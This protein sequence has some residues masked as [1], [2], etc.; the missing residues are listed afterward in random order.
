MRNAE[1][2]LAVIRKQ[3]QRG[4]SVKNVYRLLYQRDLYLHAY[5]KLYRNHG[6]MTEG[7]TSETVD[8]MSL[9]K[10]DKIIT[11]LRNE[12]YRWTPVRRVYIPKKNKKL[13]P[14]GLP[15]WS[16]KLLQ[17][18]VR[19]ILE[20]YYEPKFSKNSHGFRPKR[21]C[22]TALRGVIRKGSGTKWFIEG[23]ISACYDKIDHSIL[24]EI[25]GE[26]FQDNRFI[27]LLKGL[28]TAGY[29]EDWK[30]NKT[31]SGVPQ[32]S[33]IGPILSNIVLDRLDK[34]VEE[35]L[36]PDYTRGKMREMN[37]DYHRLNW[38]ALRL[39]KKNG[40]K[41]AH[42][43]RKQMQNMPSKNPNDS[44]FRR[45]WYVRYADDFLLGL[46]GPKNEGV[47]IKNKVANFLC[48]DL[49]LALNSEKT[50]VTHARDKKAKFLGYEIHALHNNRK[51]DHQK[52]RC[53]NGIIGLRI[54]LYV[55]R[56]MC[57][58]YKKHGKPVHM[59]QRINEEAYSIVTQYQAEYRGIVQYYRMAYNLSSL[60]EFKHVMEQSL[61]QTLARKYK[62]TCTKI[63][64]RYGTHIE[65]EEGKRRVILVRYERE[66]PKKPLIAYFGGISQKW[67][68]QASI[69]DKPPPMVLRNRNELVQRLLAQECELCGS[70]DNV[71]VHHIRKLADLKEEGRTV[72]AEWKRHMSKRQRKTL[73]VCR[74]CH[75]DI[76]H[77]RY[78]GEKLSA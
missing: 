39:E 57:N 12:Q 9:E 76:H 36:I 75:N 28:L 53:I 46:I 20:A 17:E 60:G 61:V 10:I 30:F 71:E 72:Q 74:A 63:Y 16:D 49:K 32:G 67:D 18:V 5:G 41:R 7:A 24:L 21:G 15:K 58:K 52:R 6:A 55:K 50:L 38:Q 37:P 29:L 19:V 14:L 34:Y 69:N 23:D 26:S 25:L 65:T 77:G 66:P 33:I 48:N 31:Y 42:E 8:G 43:L 11:L 62:T 1:T 40:G 35:Q 54:P 44:N 3:G 51:H 22:H 4:Q 13:R 47:E 2:I 56:E 68:K 64:K 59:L 45:L 70:H 73:I 27:R 78:D